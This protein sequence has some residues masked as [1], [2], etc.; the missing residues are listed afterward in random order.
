MVGPDQRRLAVDLLE[1]DFELSQRRAC[2]LVGQPRATQRYAKRRSTCPMLEERIVSL[3]QER[4]RFGY[5]R[6]LVLLRREG[7]DVGR[8]RVYRIYRAAGLK[9][10]SRRRKKLGRVLRGHLERPTRPNQRWSIDF[11]SDRM[12]DGRVL[13]ALTVVD[14]FTKICPLIEV[15]LSL[16]GERVARALD[17]A[18]EVQGK[19][20]LVVMDNGPEFT[21]HALEAWAYE[22]AVTLHWIDPGKPVQNAYV[23]SFN[24]RFRDECLNVHHFAGLDHARA[25]I[26][27]WREDYNDVRPHSSLGNLTPSEFIRSWVGGMPPT[28]EPYPS[29]QPTQSPV[30]TLGL[31]SAVD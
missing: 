13:C 15:D 5:P 31:T 20:S 12:S 30:E 7:F 26:E 3:A 8:R 25:L 21:S 24:G 6:I 2:E 23:E 18:I 19:P 9:L 29:F 14:D 16:S 11:V 27:L 17:R 28:Q 1:E 10:R 22:R 4:P